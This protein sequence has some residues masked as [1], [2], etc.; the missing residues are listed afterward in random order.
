MYSVDIFRPIRPDG[1]GGAHILEKVEISE[2]GSGV[3]GNVLFT[4]AFFSSSAGAAVGP[5][6]R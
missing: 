1:E 6:E 2:V 4:W 3:A 5:G